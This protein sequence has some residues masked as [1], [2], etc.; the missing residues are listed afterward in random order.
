M[1]LKRDLFPKFEF[2][3]VRRAFVFNFP[4]FPN[5]NLQYTENERKEQPFCK[6][7][8]SL[9]V[10]L[11]VFNKQ[12]QIRLKWIGETFTDTRAKVFERFSIL[13]IISNQVLFPLSEP[14]ASAKSRYL[15]KQIPTR[16]IHRGESFLR[17]FVFA[18]RRT[19]ARYYT[20]REYLY[21]YCFPELFIFYD[22]ISWTHRKQIGAILQPPWHEWISIPSRIKPGTSWCGCIASW[23]VVHTYKPLFVSSLFPRLLPPSLSLSLS[24]SFPTSHKFTSINL[25][26]EYEGVASDHFQP[27]KTALAH[28]QREIRTKR[29]HVS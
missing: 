13:T 21:R 25:Q 24:S 23:L 14:G 17:S 29:F 3:G 15:D 4:T 7:M 19:Y 28:M 10:I 16:V 18:S 20:R 2:H 6:E 11:Y 9:D 27:S 22:S 1:N 26:F 8:F 12:K 5:E